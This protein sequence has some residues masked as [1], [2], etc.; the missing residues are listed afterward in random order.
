MNA[1]D[2]GSC[3]DFVVEDVAFSILGE[4]QCRQRK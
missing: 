3:M 4:D 2:N 1:G